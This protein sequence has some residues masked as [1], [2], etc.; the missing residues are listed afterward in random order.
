[1]GEVKEDEWFCPVLE[2]TWRR[3]GRG[4][5]LAQR[6]C[7]SQRYF[8]IFFTGMMLLLLKLIPWK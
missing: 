4:S 8:V 6:L 2:D 3:C 7:R 5:N 1:M